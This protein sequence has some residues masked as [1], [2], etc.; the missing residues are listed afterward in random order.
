[1]QCKVMPEKK[2]KKKTAEFLALRGFQFT[3]SW[4]YIIVVCFIRIAFVIVKLIVFQVLR[5]NSDFG[6][7]LA[8]IW[9]N[10]PEVLTTRGSTLANKNFVWKKIEE[11]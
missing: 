1:M 10:I 3:L 2:K 9:S 11:F 7:L 5:T 6:P 4:R 8:Q